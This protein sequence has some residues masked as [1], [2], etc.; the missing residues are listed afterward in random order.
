LNQDVDKFLVYDNKT[1]LFG[2]ANYTA[3]VDG[4]C[5]ESYNYSFTKEEA[6]RKYLGE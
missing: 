4:Y 6:I 5:I 3:Y 1:G 2:V